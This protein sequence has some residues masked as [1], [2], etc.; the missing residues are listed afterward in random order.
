MYRTYVSE[1]VIE[2]GVDVQVPRSA[3]SSSF[4][5]SVLDDVRLKSLRTYGD[6]DV[7]V[8]DRGR[9]PNPFLAF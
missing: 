2:S 7:Q 9:K 4:D 5:T 1:P 6:P 8:A 3:V